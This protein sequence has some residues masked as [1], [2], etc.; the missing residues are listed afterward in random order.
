MVASAI[1]KRILAYE[2][3][4][5]GM[6]GRV[7]HALYLAIRRSGR[8]GIPVVFVPG[9]RPLVILEYRDFLGLVKGNES[10]ENRTMQDEG[11][12]GPMYE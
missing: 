3:A 7:W 2:L 9:P 11:Y 5:G 6:P 4:G 12:W 8:D 10:V 1:R